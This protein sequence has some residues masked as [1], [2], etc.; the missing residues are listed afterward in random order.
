[1]GDK[2]ITTFHSSSS[3]W[4]PRPLG[5]AAG[6]R[7]SAG[8]K[9]TKAELPRPGERG[10][11]SGFDVVCILESR[12]DNH[13]AFRPGLPSHSVAAPAWLGFTWV[14]TQKHLPQGAAP[15]KV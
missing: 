1:M 6:T 14:L 2:L 10:G 13:T 15:G 7:L 12:Q 5:P 3:H 4:S 8:Q 11:H 9:K